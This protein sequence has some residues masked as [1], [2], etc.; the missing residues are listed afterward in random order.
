M[1]IILA[2]LGWH[3]VFAQNKV[4]VSI[5]PYE[6]LTTELGVG[7]RL[8]SIMGSPNVQLSNL[9]QYRVSKRFV[10]AS[11]TGYYHNVPNSRIVDVEQ[12]HSFSMFQ[13]LGLGLPLSKKINSSALLFLAGF[14]YDRYSG[15]LL[16]DEISETVTTESESTNLDYGIM[17]NMRMGRK[18]YFISSRIYVPLKDGLYG[19]VEGATMDLGVG[20]RIR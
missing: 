6:R 3:V 18:K 11:Q 5:R 12:N 16:N 15:T 8:M 9:L 14:R 17:Y 20:L 4:D 10:L 13:R 7:T 19:I 1:F 2:S